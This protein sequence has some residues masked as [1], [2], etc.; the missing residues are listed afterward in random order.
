VVTLLSRTSGEE[1]AL[2]QKST[3]QIANVGIAW[4][5]VLSAAAILPLLTIEFPPL[6][7]FYHWV[8]QGHITRLLL[9]GGS[10]ATGSVDLAYRLSATPV[11]DSAAPLGIAVLN[12]WLPSLAAGRV[13]LALAI[14]AF[15]AGFAYLVRSVQQRAT[16][17]E[18]LGFPWA[19]G[20]F[21]YKGYDSYLVSLAVA[22]I[23]I[24]ILHRSTAQGTRLPG[25]TNLLALTVLGVLLFLCHLLG[26]AVFSLAAGVYTLW[27][28]RRRNGRGS[29]LLL[30]TLIPAMILLVVY[31]IGESGQSGG[32]AIQLY[33]ALSEKFLALVEPLMLFL[34]TDPFAPVLPIFWLNAAGLLLFA[35]IAVV[36]LD[37][38]RPPAKSVSL[39]LLALAALLLVLSLVLPFAQVGGLLSPDGRFMLP[40]VLIAITALRF[41]GLTFRAGGLVGFLILLVIGFH[42]A[43]Y[44]Q[45][46][47]SFQAIKVST[48]AAI[49]PG[50]PVLSLSVF[51]DALH[52]GCGQES[53]GFTIGAPTLKWFDLYL[54]S[55]RQELEANIMETSVVRTRSDGEGLPDLTVLT[56]SAKDLQAQPP[57]GQQ[58]AS[59]YAVVEAF[60]CPKDMGTV[61][62]AFTPQYTSF[63]QGDNFVI[64][65]RK[66]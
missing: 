46:D 58:Y 2:S 63:A 61:V 24:G 17:I 45:A 52:G 31:A 3:I 32:T 42:F 54:L 26:W 49:P 37:H 28:L 11:P 6:Y 33:A 30:A 48:L 19:F 16:A 55:Q 21:L 51:E 62:Q 56:L 34:R 64:L 14:V 1:T 7:D 59:S 23:A 43:E 13:F 18:F 8:F 4:W 29:L 38:E 39:P 50:V 40:G 10:D 65:H 20:Y 22:F 15:A 66:P 60:G 12:L 9:F 53:A 27:L 36:E 5:L 41:K 44:Q 57:L 47:R 25:R 35:A